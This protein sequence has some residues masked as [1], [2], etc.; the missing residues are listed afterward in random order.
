MKVW[1]MENENQI[2]YAVA[3]AATFEEATR[4]VAE[5]SHTDES[6]WT[7]EE[8]S[9]NSNGNGIVFFS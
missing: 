2:M 3:Y 5:L 6:E 1:S 4:K 8:F 7:G 9:E